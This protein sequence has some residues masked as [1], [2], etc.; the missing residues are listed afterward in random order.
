[1]EADCNRDALGWINRW[2]EWPGFALALAGPEGS[3]ESHLAH[4]F[5]VRSGAA[6][7]PA[8]ALTVTM[9]GDLGGMVIEDADRGVDQTALFHLYNLA[10]GSRSGRCC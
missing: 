10:C 6:I 5:A 4:I 8:A 2:P 3:G 1:M 9:V 7:L